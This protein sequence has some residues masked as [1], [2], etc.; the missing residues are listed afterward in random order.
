[1]SPKSE[2]RAKKLVSVS[3]TS[4]PVIETRVETVETIEAASKDSKKSESEYPE[5]LV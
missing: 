5:N 4:T 3:K 1:M 2:K